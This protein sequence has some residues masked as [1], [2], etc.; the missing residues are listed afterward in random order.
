M[1][2]LKVQSWKMLRMSGLGAA[3]AQHQTRNWIRV[4]NPEALI[5]ENVG[6]SSRKSKN[7]I[8]VLHAIANEGRNANLIVLTIRRQRQFKNKYEEAMALAELYPE[9]AQCIPARKRKCFD[10]E[11]R[12]M[13]FFEAL[14]LFH[15]ANGLDFHPAD[16]L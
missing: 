11:P 14:S 5:T 12:K 8:R 10:C 13:I 6:L 16:R 9:M 3:E 7:T 4:M 2:G 15:I 1:V